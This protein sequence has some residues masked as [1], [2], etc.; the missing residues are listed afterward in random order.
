MGIEVPIW[1]LKGPVGALNWAKM[2]TNQQASRI[3]LIV[4]DVLQTLMECGVDASVLG[5]VAVKLPAKIA[6]RMPVVPEKEATPVS[7]DVAQLVQQAVQHELAKL[8][9]QSTQG[10]LNSLAI[11]TRKIRV[12]VNKT[13]L[14]LPESLYQQAQAHFGS[15]RL[16]NAAI[17]KL[18]EQA[19]EN[20]IRSRWIAQ[21]LQQFLQ[22]AQKMSEPRAS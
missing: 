3:E 16:A 5:P 19:P 4:G 17:R 12:K 15:P 1:E 8:Q 6:R 20:S 14:L 11:D 22:T 13:T 9:A 10:L 21:Q 18:H 2:D 7:A